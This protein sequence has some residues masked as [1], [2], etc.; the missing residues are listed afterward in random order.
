DLGF[1]FRHTEIDE[2]FADLL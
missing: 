1:E 2:A